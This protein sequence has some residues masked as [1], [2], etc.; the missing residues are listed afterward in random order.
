[1]SLQFVTDGKKYDLST[2]QFIVTL[3][4]TIGAVLKMAGF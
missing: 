1:M 3:L 4:L 2:F